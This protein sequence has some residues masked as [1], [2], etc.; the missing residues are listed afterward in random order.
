MIVKIELSFFGLISM[1]LIKSKEKCFL[2]KRNFN[3]LYIVQK[4]KSYL[5]N[6]ID[7]LKKKNCLNWSR[8]AQNE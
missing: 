4:Y 5:Q 2:N 6:A 8:I 3:K 1:K 7:T